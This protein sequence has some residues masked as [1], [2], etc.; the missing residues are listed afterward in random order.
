MNSFQE[1][2]LDLMKEFDRIC[3]EN[4]IQYFFA[5]GTALGAVRNG[6]FLP[7]DDDVDVLIKRSEYEKLDKVMNSLPL[8]G[9][10][11]VTE[12]TYPTYRNPTPRF[13]D[14]N[15][16]DILVSRLDYGAP[17]G[18]QIEVFIMDPYPNEEEKRIDF[19][20]H[21]W[22]YSE[23][24][25]HYIFYGRN[26]MPDKM[27]DIEL[28]HHYKDLLREKGVAYVK[29][30]LLKHITYP[31]EECDC[32]CG[33][34]SC[35]PYVFKK[36]W[37]ASQKMVMFEGIK[38]PVP[39]GVY[40]EMLENYDA[41]WD[42][43]P[44]VKKRKV[45]PSLKSST[46]EYTRFESSIRK[47]CDEVGYND[48]IA[49][50]KEDRLERFASRLAIE[51]QFSLVRKAYLGEIAGRFNQF[52]W[53]YEREKQ[54]FFEECFEEFF[55]TLF[56]QSYRKYKLAVPLNDDLLETILLTLIH[57]NE[58]ENALFLVQLYPGFSG[59]SQYLKVCSHILDAK[60]GKY[61]MDADLCRKLLAE[62]SEIPE[63]YGQ[64]EI[65]RTRMWLNSIS[66]IRT[67]DEIERMLQDC[68]HPDD[69][70][71][72]KYAG[73]MYEKAGALQLM[74]ECYEKV[75]KKSRNGMILYDLKKRGF[76]A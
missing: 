59:Q 72:V 67:V 31:E 28:Y 6:G 48:L 36:E 64:I 70:E 18:L 41:N 15:S 17:K 49:A 37:M 20:K 53:K 61:D 22:L 33:R 68:T 12:E 40:Y 7:W 38:I 44:P 54:E 55:L 46:I 11:W 62:L 69:L 10:A 3:R 50:N 5:G 42:I 1:V 65:E 30:E 63:L 51:K 45:H 2:L 27:F 14:L 35:I 13:F 34:W 39:A 32:Y 16:T 71:I 43:I 66:E 56:K 4:N 21:L 8:K 57:K 29:Q 76:C 26:D 58:I 25:N 60:I 47:W 74:N 19:N 9:R 73:D 75:I 23:V 52:S 24:T